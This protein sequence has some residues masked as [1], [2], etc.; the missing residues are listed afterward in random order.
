[1]KFSKYLPPTILIATI[2]GFWGLL[3]Y[4]SPNYFLYDDNVNQFLAYAKFNWESIVE[5]L[6]IP[7]I[8]YYQYLGQDYLGQG[9]NSI[10]SPSLYLAVFLS[11]SISSNYF[12]TVDILMLI[13]LIVAGIGFYY[14]CHYLKISEILAVFGTLLWL[15]LPFQVMISKSWFAVINIYPFLPLNLVL[16][17]ALLDKPRF[18]IAFLLG[19]VKALSYVCGHAHFVIIMIY[20]E[21]LFV[22][23]HFIT[24]NVFL[25]K[26]RLRIFSLQIGLLTFDYKRAYKIFYNFVPFYFLSFIT[27]LALSAPQL[28]PTIIAKN[29]SAL[30]FEP[31]VFEKILMNSI[32]P[33]VFF[34]SQFGLFEKPIFF[35][36]KSVMLFI[37]FPLLFLLLLFSESI[38]QNK[39]INLTITLVL[40]SALVFLLGTKAYKFTLFLPFFNSFRW[41]IKHYLY[42]LFFFSIL[43]VFLCNCYLMKNGDIKDKIL[44][45]GIFLVSITM[46]ILINHYFASGNKN[47]F[48]PFHIK[49][50]TEDPFHDVIKKKKGR[51]ITIGFRNDF[52]INNYLNHNNTFEYLL[53]TFP[54]FWKYFHFNGYDPLVS[55]KNFHAGLANFQISQKHMNLVDLNELDYYLEHLN[56]WSGR[57][58]ITYQSQKV[59]K[60]IS[61]YPHFE[62]IHNSDKHLIYENRKAFPIVYL[63]SDQNTAVKYKFAINKIMIFPNNKEDDYLVITVVPL[64]GYSYKIGYQGQYKP[65]AV[66][67]SRIKKYRKINNHMKKIATDQNRSALYPD[68]YLKMVKENIQPI[69]VKIPRNTDYVEIKYKNKYFFYGIY[70]TCIYTIICIVGFILKKAIIKK[71]RI[72]RIIPFVR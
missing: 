57:Y 54:T 2:F 12:W 45:Y 16:I 17:F 34:Q 11:K 62:L 7:H 67:N 42:F 15:T 39:T 14:L 35:W 64:N 52:G 56:T 60:K 53:F 32:N 72:H 44:I 70:I 23:I 5:K 29:V 33:I 13:H 9:Q 43:V 51:V 30:R 46:N 36:G 21:I 31:L 58:L 20:T 40:I 1:M 38:R 25:S 22:L 66:F 65:I 19:V 18:S 41:I 63:E 50:H 28:F 27:F 69:K 47:A 49:N 8:N 37:G 10:L 68:I 4:Y 61:K 48:G 24:L 6:T 59:F 3:Q 71:E 26:N 55:E